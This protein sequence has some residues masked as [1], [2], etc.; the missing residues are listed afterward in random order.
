MR[1]II[2]SALRGRLDEAM[3]RELHKLGPEAVALAMLSTS[4][5]IAELQSNVETERPSGST[6][7]GV[8]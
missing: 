4:K 7:G 3:A 8:A 5:R 2:D 1:A 6:R